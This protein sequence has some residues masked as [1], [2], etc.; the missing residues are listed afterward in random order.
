M[1]WKDSHDAIES[2][3]ESGEDQ[4]EENY[5]PL[6]SGKL[7]LGMIISFIAKNPLIWIITIDVVL[8][9]I[10]ALII[11]GG[12]DG[13]KQLEAFNDRIS[14]L[15]TQV[16]ALDG[17][18][19]LVA[20]FEKNQKNVK[21]LLVRIDRLETTMAAKLNEMAEQIDRLQKKTASVSTRQSSTQSAKKRAMARK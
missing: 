2:N 12:G 3:H 7:G 17:I 5:S 4:F 18:N 8:V 13:N 19:N 21:A 6:K 11:P 9:I 16:T 14:R 15:E 10:I 1:K 20:E